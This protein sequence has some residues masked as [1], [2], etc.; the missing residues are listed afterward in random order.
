MA[1][2]PTPQQVTAEIIKV[3]YESGA[4]KWTV[5]EKGILIAAIKQQLA[6]R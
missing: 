5:Q 3:L 6:E 2:K 4:N 1:D